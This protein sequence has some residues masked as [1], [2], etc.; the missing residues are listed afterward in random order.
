MGNCVGRQRGERPAAPGHPRKRA[1]NDGEGSRARAPLLW[2]PHPRPDL[3]RLLAPG[4]SR[5]ET[6][7]RGGGLPTPGCRGSRVGAPGSADPAS[8]S[9]S[10]NWETWVGAGAGA[11]AGNVSRPQRGRRRGGGR[12]G[13]PLAWPPGRGRMPAGWGAARVAGRPQNSASEAR[14]A[15]P[16]KGCVISLSGC[17]SC[18][19]DP[20]C[21]STAGLWERNLYFS[22]QG[23]LESPGRLGV[24]EKRGI[25]LGFVGILPGRGNG[26]CS[27]VIREGRAAPA[28]FLGAL[29]SRRF[30]SGR[31]LTVVAPVSASS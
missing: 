13:A 20:T 22:L 3:P 17:R 10:S 8:S 23:F 7:R 5:S 14:T 28:H 30:A 24:L 25:A 15:A 31:S 26:I 6:W 21:K 1:G 9:T 16:S 4:F 11:G 2:C 12:G 29:L 18:L 19:P 27:L